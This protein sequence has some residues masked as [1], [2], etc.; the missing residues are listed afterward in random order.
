MKSRIPQLVQ[1]KF[2]QAV[3]DFL[4]HLGNPHAF[5]HHELAGN[6]HAIR[7]IGAQ[8]VVDAAILTLL[9]PTKTAVGHLLR[10]EILK[11]PQKHVALR[12]LKLLAGNA[13]SYQFFKR[14]KEGSRVGHGNDFSGNDSSG[15]F[16]P[17]AMHCHY[18]NDERLPINS[19]TAHSSPTGVVES[20]LEDNPLFSPIAR[21]DESPAFLLD[22]DQFD[23][24]KFRKNPIELIQF[25]SY[26]RNIDLDSY[27]KLYSS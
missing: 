16:W 15:S 1:A 19:A 8:I 14:T 9:V 18:K 2:P 24:K 10:R 5:L 7:R 12:H 13:D 23:G 4:G 25:R 27:T 20:L 17:E 3:P 22:I 26:K 21:E 11:G 6:R